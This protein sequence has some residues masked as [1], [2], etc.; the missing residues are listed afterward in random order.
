MVLPVEHRDGDKHASTNARAH[1]PR[2]DA[3]SQMNQNYAVG[4]L[5]SSRVGD[6]MIA[7]ENIQM[8]QYKQW[9]GVLY[10]PDGWRTSNVPTDNSF[11]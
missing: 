2:A 5:K 4:K 11:K 10:S 1:Y 8:V 3:R 7:R 9:I 6:T